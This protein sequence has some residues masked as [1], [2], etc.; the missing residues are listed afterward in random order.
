MSEIPPLDSSSE[1]AQEPDL[2]QPSREQRIEALRHLAGTEVSRQE[3]VP[4]AAPTSRP[5]GKRWPVM[6]LLGV[7]IVGFLAVLAIH[8][9]SSGPS[10][11]ASKAERPL[12]I[13]PGHDQ[14]DCPH[15]M[16]WFPTGDR[17][18][19]LAYQY[20]CP[21]QEYTENPQNFLSYTGAFT[22]V[23]GLVNIYDTKKGKL[24]S[25]FYPSALL[26][27]HF[28][29]S[30]AVIDVY[31]SAG[32]SPDAILGFNFTHI[33]WSANGQRLA[34]T[35]YVYV[36][37]AP[38]NPTA[39][40]STLPPGQAVD[41]VLITDLAG[42]HPQVLMHMINQAQP[43]VTVWDLSSSSVVPQPA[44]LA[45][46]ST[47]ASLTPALSYR[48]GPGGTLVPQDLLAT[49]GTPVA[50]AATPV[51]NPDGS[52]SFSIW[53]PAWVLNSIPGGNF[54][55]PLQG[56]YP[57]TT[58]IAAWSPDG[59][60]LAERVDL[61][62]LLTSAAEPAPQAGQL[63]LY[64]W[65]SAPLIPVR[66]A[67]LVQI[68][69]I[70]SASSFTEAAA[71]Y[72]QLTGVLVSWSPD[73]SLVAVNADTT[74]DEVD[75]YDCRTGKPVYSYKPQLQGGLPPAVQGE[76]N[77]LRW[78]ANGTRLALFDSARGIVTIWTVTIA[79]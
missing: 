24:L 73:G 35:F 5:L 17:L 6:V 10:S 36:P 69:R 37:T 42:T 78:S 49:Q 19:I 15:D 48:W 30:P 75:L 50:P 25:Q 23:P 59:R 63:A 77:L 71:L 68:E 8:F 31:G 72:T 16:A 62:G 66:D 79:R 20:K 18:A 44:S 21:A 7:V 52:L 26:L 46:P 64:H 40:P 74:T 1:H 45:F 33:L 32:I 11:K 61:E 65:T 38:P 34:I 14:L 70:A 54:Q 4:P 29:L 53:Q 58:D 22:S 3:A 43:S 47:F 57:Y 67:G 76:G 51:G 27:P 56:A 9:T 12:Q 60:Y 39:P 55:Q 28:K 2:W 41:G 13:V